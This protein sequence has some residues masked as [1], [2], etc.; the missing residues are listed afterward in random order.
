MSVFF[1]S[2]KDL[3]LGSKNSTLKQEVFSCPA[4]RD[5]H[6]SGYASVIFRVDDG[7][8]SV[9]A[10]C[11]PNMFA[12][13]NTDTQG[14]GREMAGGSIDPRT[15]YLY[16]KTGLDLGGDLDDAAADES[17]MKKLNTSTYV[18]FLIW[19]PA[20]G[21]Y[22]DSR[23]VQPQSLQQRSWYFMKNSAWFAG[24]RENYSRA[25]RGDFVL[26]DLVRSDATVGLGRAYRS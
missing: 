15:G 9:W 3:E 14:Y 10:S 2:P 12:R 6:G 25:N 8:D 26:G 17:G 22:V 16:M 19:D 4:D 1:W 23:P 21:R 24:R 7:S 11:F 13:S 18:Q 20:T 5:S